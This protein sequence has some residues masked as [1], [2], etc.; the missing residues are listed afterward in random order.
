MCRY[1]YVICACCILVSWRGLCVCIN[2]VLYL[3]SWNQLA[4]EASVAS[5]TGHNYSNEAPQGFTPE[6]GGH[7]YEAVDHDDSKCLL[8]YVCTCFVSYSLRRACRFVHLYVS[9]SWVES[10]TPV[11]S[12]SS[13][14][15]T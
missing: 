6:G 11:F 7:I 4:E 13:I 9:I 8:I 1:L 15:E 5:Q 12:L 10:F 14:S 2:A 3:V